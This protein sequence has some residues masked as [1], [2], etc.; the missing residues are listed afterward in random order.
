MGLNGVVYIA[1]LEGTNLL[2]IGYSSSNAQNRVR[3]WST[4]SP[5]QVIVVKEIGGTKRLEQELHARY[6]E[7][8]IE[9]SGREWFKASKSMVSQL[10]LPMCVLDGLA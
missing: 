1:W 6:A 7:N 4:G 5:G 9:A 8:R 10:G 3:N 2:K